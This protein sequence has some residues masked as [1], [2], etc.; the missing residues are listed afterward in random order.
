ML[1][2]LKQPFLNA[3]DKALTRAIRKRLGYTPRNLD[4]YKEALTHGSTLTHQNGTA[5]NCCERLEFLGDAVIEIV[6]SHYLYNNFPE[7]REGFLTQM[8][9]RL[10]SR[11]YLA[12][13]AAQMGLQPLLSTY[14]VNITKNILGN[15]FEALIGAM[16][17]DIGYKQTTKYFTAHILKAL[18]DVEDM[19]YKLVD[20]KSRLLEVVQHKPHWKADFATTDR[21]VGHNKHVFHCIVRINNEVYG[22]GKGAIKK[23]AEQ[24]AAQKALDKLGYKT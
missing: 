9:S 12:D 19:Q 11:Q 8:R 4:L 24:N 22:E 1:W 7:R 13:L 20:F 2:L 18:A 23:E 14:N 10:V 16:Y 3:K 6:V 21:K 5:I 17:L 15:A